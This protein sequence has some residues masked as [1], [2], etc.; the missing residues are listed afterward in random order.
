MSDKN[1]FMKI[2]NNQIYEEIKALRKDVNK[3]KSGITLNRW[4]STTALS[5]IIALAFG[6]MAGEI[7]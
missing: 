2:T 1:C 7:L 4:I 6:I 5:L 3:M